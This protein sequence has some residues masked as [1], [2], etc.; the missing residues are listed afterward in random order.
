MP[1]IDRVTEMLTISGWYYR[2]L[3]EGWMGIGDQIVLVE[4]QHPEWTIERIQEYLHRDKENLTKL[5][6]LER[7]EEFG[8]EC[9]DA[10]K[11]RV[12]KLKEPLKKKEPE[13]WEEFK[14]VEKKKQ[15]DRITSFVLEKDG[16]VEEL[17]PGFF[18]RLKLPNGLIRPYSIVGGDTHRIEL[19]IALEEESRGGSRYLHQNVKQGDNILV[20]KITES[21]PIKEQASNH[22]F[23]AGGI[24]ITAFFMHCNIYN[25]IN[26]NYELHY[27]V[28]SSEDL[29]FNDLL[30]KMG[31]RLFIY[32]KSKGQRMDIP[33]ILHN[34]KWNSFVYAC[35][36]QRM[37]DDLVRSSNACGMTHDDIHY[38]AFQI[39]TSGDPFEVELAKSNKTLLVDGDKTLLQVIREA[40]LE[41]DSSCE[42]GN[43]GTCRVEVCSGKVDH[44]GSAL[45]EEEKGKAMLTCVSRGIDHIV[46]DF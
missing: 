27:A 24:G 4:R 26:F 28:R 37:I 41:V 29:P 22:I 7:I 42:T 46:I 33:A 31:S 12:V 45:S 9:K 32:D 10:F 3:E 39:A 8:D 30:N 43:C 17:D 38:E 16:K 6:E 36:P 40:G 18:V 44:R 11:S 15:T 1:C 19:G 20:G 13:K 14:V 2:V 23:I 25:Q 34:R 35:G 21:V 5:E